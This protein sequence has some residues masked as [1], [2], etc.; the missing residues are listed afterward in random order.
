MERERQGAGEGEK[1]KERL[2]VVKKLRTG[3]DARCSFGVL[4][5][6]ADASADSRIAGGGLLACMGEVSFDL[7]SPRTSHAS[8]PSSTIRTQI[9]R[10]SSELRQTN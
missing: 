9:S 7:P 8:A 6:W 3:R 5:A 10:P 2:R 4:V 1:G